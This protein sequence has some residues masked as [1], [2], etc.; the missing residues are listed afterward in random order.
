[1]SDVKARVL[2]ADPDPD[3]SR[4][5]TIYFNDHG[6]HVETVE[7][8]ALVFNR[9]RQWQPDAIL[10]STEF[11]DV[12]PYHVCQHIL[13]D[14]RTAHIPTI[15]LLHLNDRKSRLAALEVGV[16]DVVAK[17]IDL[18]ELR[19]RMEAAIRLAALRVQP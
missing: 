8:A 3:V 14:P 12:N 17:P 16:D 6:Y 15:M 11:V 7:L 5:L 2:V 9:A 1:M 18:E 4:T 13:E 19:L 10:V